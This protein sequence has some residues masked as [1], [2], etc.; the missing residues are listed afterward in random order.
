M[1]WRAA[2]L[3]ALSTVNGLRVH[4][5]G[6]IR[7]SYRLK[8]TSAASTMI[9]E[10]L[11]EPA[12]PV[13]PDKPV[14]KPLLAFSF[15]PGGLLFPYQLGVS[16]ELARAGLLTES[17]PLAGSS[18]GALTCAVIGCGLELG[19]VL[20]A[21]AKLFEDCRTNGTRG[22]LQSVLKLSLHDMLPHDA[23]E[24]MTRRQAPVGV[25]YTAMTPL[26]RGRIVT[27]FTSK[28]DLIECL[29][30]SCT[31]PFWFNSA[32]YSNVRG[33]IGVDGFF[34]VP[35]KYFGAPKLRGARR[36]VRISVFPSN[37]VKVASDYEGDV[38][39]P[40][41]MDPDRFTTMPPT[42]SG[43][44]MGLALNPGTEE[45]LYELFAMGRDS[46]RKWILEHGEK[47]L[48]DAALE[49]NLEENEA[50]E[51]D[52]QE[53]QEDVM[54]ALATFTS[55]FTSGKAFTLGKDPA[56]K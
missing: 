19:A 7:I 25:A 38:I 20:E 9:P 17:T 46:G 37:I 54:G 5:S 34:A 18:A 41:G 53:E 11:S 51:I 35:R 4:S 32:A 13:V 43:G 15:T 50:L 45:Q 44:M 24:R 49:Q 2:F 14:K 3:V 23:H 10:D 22:R 29:L 30:A 42:S 8:M 1:P 33:E 28:E 16:H 36:T 6:V 12:V 47:M 26:P 56:S 39:C 52:E 55:F 48:A 27:T 21:T 40:D 31:V